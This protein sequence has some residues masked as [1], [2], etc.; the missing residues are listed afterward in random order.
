MGSGY[1]LFTPGGFYY[2]VS[3]RVGYYVLGK[4]NVFYQDEIYRKSPSIED[5]EFIIDVEFF[6][7]GWA[8]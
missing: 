3:I 5:R 8:F 2:G 1:R 4:N 7:L 6:K